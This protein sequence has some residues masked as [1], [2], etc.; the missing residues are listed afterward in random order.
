MD[1]RAL[2]EILRKNLPVISSADSRICV[3]RY[4][5]GHPDLLVWH[6]K[7]RIEIGNFCSIGDRVTVLGGGEHRPDWVTTYPLR[8]AFGDERAYRDG[9]PRTKG[10]VRI[11]SDV[12]VGFGSIILSGV[13]IGDGA[14]IGA[15]SVVTK[16]VPPYA[17]AAGNPARVIRL[18]FSKT[19]IKKMLQIRWWDWP[20]EKIREAAPLLS[21]SK[22]ENF[23]K[24]AG[25]Q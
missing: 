9:H 25:K 18:R 7:D 20:L 12:W 17:I 6:P 3:G 22:I 21:D 2:D 10:P 13:R 15:G 8:I 24:Y 11:G 23:L 5:Y 1:P 4:N 14:V 16:D 19:Q